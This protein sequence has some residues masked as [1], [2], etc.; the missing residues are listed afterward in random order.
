[1]AT[2]ASLLGLLGC[3]TVKQ[4]TE[5]GHLASGPFEIRWEVAYTASRAWYNLGSRPGGQD[6][7]SYFQVS[8]H[9]KPV[10]VP[11]R[12]GTT[13]SYFWQ[14]LFLKDAPKPA[15]LIGTHQ[16]YL[17]T[18]VDGQASVKLLDAEEGDF[19]KYQWLD[20]EKGQPGAQHKIYQIDN[21]KASR[22]LSGG[23]YL[24]VNTR[25]LLDTQLLTTYRIDNNSSALV[26]QLDGYNAF[27]SEVVYLSPGKTQLVLI[28]YRRNPQ[29]NVSEYALVCID[30]RRNKTYAVPFDRT[31]TRFFSIWDATP[32]WVSTY[33]DWTVTPEGKE[34]MNLHPFDRLPYWQGRLE[35]H[36]NTDQPAQYQLRP[37]LPGMIAHFMDCV[38]HQYPTITKV[39]T[40]ETS[41]QIITDFSLD[42]KQITLYF[43]K[44]DKTLT[45]L[46]ADKGLIKTLGDRFEQELA[47]GNFQQEFGRFDFD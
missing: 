37:V 4:K 42:E 1:M 29:T 20:S 47:K 31:A 17:I 19:G 2:L 32:A 28:G 43:N 30:F 39:E 27:Q 45:L 7:T 12:N 44:R 21:S 5:T 36:A 41:E 40:R 9:G 35:L 3:K 13:T 38:R 15:V 23:R 34:T 6:A 46:H 25:T 11:A 22:F 33:F 16:M 18:E 10:E 24:M 14:A 26:Q 8:Y